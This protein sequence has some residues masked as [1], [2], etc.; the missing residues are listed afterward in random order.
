MENNVSLLLQFRLYRLWE[1]IN[2]RVQKA[3]RKKEGRNAEPT[4]MIIDCQSVKS[5]E[6]GEAIGFD[7]NKKVHG[8]KRV[9][10][11]DTLGLSRLVK[12]VARISMFVACLDLS[13]C[14]LS[15]DIWANLRDHILRITIYRVERYEIT[16]TA[17]N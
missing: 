4:A 15:I 6:G 8:L 9:L 10:L 3:A 14:L 17:G 1:E 16:Q 13:D 7:D 2:E 11:T 5:A 12:V